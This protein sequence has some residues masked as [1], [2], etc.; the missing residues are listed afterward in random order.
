MEELLG[1]GGRGTRWDAPGKKP[2]SHPWDPRRFYPSAMRTKFAL[3]AT[4]PLAV[5]SLL[6]PA[7][8]LAGTDMVST[9]IG[10]ME[11][12]IDGGEF[13]EECTDFPYTVEVTG[14]GAGVDWSADIEASRSGGRSTPSA[15]STG[16]GSGTVGGSIMICSGV[17]GAGD[18]TATVAVT[19]THPTDTTKVY[20]RT[21]TID[22][23]VSK[24]ET[25]TTIT[26]V[27]ERSGST[28]VKG[29]VLT[30]SGL[31]DP[32]MFGEVTIKVKKS[33]GSWKTKGTEQVDEDGNFSATIDRTYE[34]G[35]KFKAVFGGTD[36]AKGST[37]SIWEL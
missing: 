33:G 31:S 2:G 21:M 20:D 30:T 5:A 27:R 22:F 16:S 23:T 8:A 19:F 12:T 34:S 13:T 15:M 37:S 24:A 14:A 17:D 36:E 26:N 32:T 29:T 1:E 35:T 10:S 28:K 11:L 4:I 18:Y 25:D 9:P 6:A 3:A 7:A